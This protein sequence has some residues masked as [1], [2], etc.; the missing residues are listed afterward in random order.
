M[1]FAFHDSRKTAVIDGAQSVKSAVEYKIHVVQLARKVCKKTSRRSRASMIV[2]VC[3]RKSY[4]AEICR[5]LSTV[6]YRS[7]YSGKLIARITAVPRYKE[8][9]HKQKS[10]ILV[11]RIGRRVNELPRSLNLIPCGAT[12]RHGCGRIDGAS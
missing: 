8:V 10:P 3:R 2:I 4:S 9:F 5:F 12:K 7:G 1:D 6:V 11:P